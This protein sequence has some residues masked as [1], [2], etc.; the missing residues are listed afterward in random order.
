M[1][2]AKQIPT[3]PLMMALGALKRKDPTAFNALLE[4]LGVDRWSD[5]DPSKWGEAVA[6]CSAATGRTFK[7]PQAADAESPDVSDAE[8]AGELSGD[9]EDNATLRAVYEKAYGKTPPLKNLATHAHGKTTA[10]KLDSM[11]RFDNFARR[12]AHSARESGHAK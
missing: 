4:K 12:V 9:P 2:N 8:V 3:L 6:T 1:S 7:L 10:E 5:I 11:G